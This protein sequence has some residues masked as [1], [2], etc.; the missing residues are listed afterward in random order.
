MNEV[1]ESPSKPEVQRMPFGVMPKTK[2]MKTKNGVPAGLPKRKLDLEELGERK[3]TQAAP[4]S[5]TGAHPNF[6]YHGGYIVSNPQLYSIF[7][8]DW[9]SAVNQQRAS[10]LNQFLRD[11]VQ[12]NYMNISSQYGCGSAGNFIASVFIPSS[13]H[14]FADNDFHSTL[15][16]A[17]NNHQIPEPTN[18]NNC[19][20]IFLDDAAAVKSGSI[21]MCEPNSDTAFGYHNFFKT[22]GGNMCYYAIIPSLIDSCLQNS[23][24]GGD[25]TCS[26]RLTQTREQRQTQVTSHEFSEMISDP[27]LNAW[28]DESTGDEDGD[29]CNGLSASITVGP[30]SWNVQLM[31]S[32]IDDLR[33]NGAVTCISGAAAPTPRLIPVEI[34]KVT[35]GDT[36]SQAPS[37][38]LHNGTLFLAW[39]GTGNN[40]INVMSSVDGIHFVNKVTLGETSFSKPAICSH[41]NQLYLAW[42]GTDGNHS[43][44]VLSSADGIHWGN[45]V[46]MGDNSIAAPALASFNG[47]L[48]IGW[49]GTDNNHSLNVMS[50]VDGIHFGGKSTL[51]DN[52]F[53]GPS[54]LSFN[55]NLHM[56]WTGTDTHHSLNINQS[57]DG[58]HFGNKTI[59]AESSGATTELST[60]GNTIWVCWGGTPNLQI[61]FITVPAQTIKV[62]LGETAVGAP[63]IAYP[64]FAWTG[65]DLQHHLNVAKI[66]R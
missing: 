6:T 58:V 25:G 57:S 9:T 11:I 46:T 36:S 44:N 17:I 23:C 31:Y 50:S 49:T 22:A 54:L 51:G 64:Y 3:D 30:N 38:C 40:E 37:I 18:R 4:A 66:L 21:V 1:L 8:G 61:N 45:K 65:T 29:I 15:Q 27:E 20:L 33:S 60:D 24:P 41:N 47:K 19:Y 53:T 56:G 2:K 26:L 13:Q 63:A 32:K 43:L 12:S 16:T 5:G 39:T 62:T 28:L 14:Q 7:L 59:L 55:G 52:S 48:Y 35:L 34:D 42:T 10:R